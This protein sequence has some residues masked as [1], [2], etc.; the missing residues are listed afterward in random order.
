MGNVGIEVAVKAG[1]APADISSP[2]ALH[3]T[4]L[5]AKSITCM[6]PQKGTRGKHFAAV[7]TQLGIASQVQAKTSLGDVGFV[8][9]PVAKGE[10]GIQQITDILPVQDALASSLRRSKPMA[11]SCCSS[12]S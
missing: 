10:I 3:Q 9:E 11:P 12:C 6:D 2:D 1:A 4:L 7:L 8:V 5:N